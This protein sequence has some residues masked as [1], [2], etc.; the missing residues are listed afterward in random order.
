[1][2]TLNKSQNWAWTLI[3]WNCSYVGASL[4]AAG[5]FFE[6]DTNG[7]DPS[8]SQPI[9]G[10]PLYSPRISFSTISGFYDVQPNTTGSNYPVS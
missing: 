2:E 6:I 7:T 1:M 3:D 5:P 9:N 4:A 8:G 10:W